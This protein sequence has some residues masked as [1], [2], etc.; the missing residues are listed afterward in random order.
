MRPV[1]DAACVS[2]SAHTVQDF[3]L[4]LCSEINELTMLKI[5]SP[6]VIPSSVLKKSMCSRKSLVST[7]LAK[8][9]QLRPVH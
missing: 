6:V 5:S 2:V 1:I 9:N 4:I 8:S 3:Q 7:Y